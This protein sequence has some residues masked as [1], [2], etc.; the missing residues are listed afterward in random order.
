MHSAYVNNL[1]QILVENLCDGW[2]TVDFFN[3][4]EPQLF[5]S[6]QYKQIKN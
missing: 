3:S 6:F 4:R 1:I 2:L 5:K